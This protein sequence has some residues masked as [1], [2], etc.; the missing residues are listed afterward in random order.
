MCPFSVLCGIAAFFSALSAIIHIYMCQFQIVYVLC[1]IIP[2]VYVSVTIF[3]H[4]TRNYSHLLCAIINFS[5]RYA[6]PC[7]SFVSH[8]QLFSLLCG[9]TVIFHVSI[10]NFLRAMR[11]NSHRYVSLSSVPC[12]MHNHTHLLC[13]C[14]NFSLRYA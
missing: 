11:D 12:A 7:L 1:T 5:P 13:V 9:I 2:I 3:L 4:A 10:S 6:L 8:H 14:S